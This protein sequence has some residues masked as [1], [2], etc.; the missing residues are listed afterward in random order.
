MSIPDFAAYL[1]AYMV[2]GVV[3]VL[4]SL[5]LTP[6]GKI[7]RGA[8][9]DV[10][11]PTGATAPRSRAEAVI[12]GI[13]ESVLGIAGIGVHD[14]FFALGAHSLTLV[15]IAA[16]LRQRLGAT[17]SVASLF[18]APT[19]A[20]VAR[21]VATG[22]PAGDPLAPVLTLHAGGVGA[23]LFCLPP[24]SG[25]TW[26]YAALRRY[27]D[28]PLV[29]LQSPTLSG[30]P[31]PASLAALAG[32]HA[33][34]IVALQPDGPVRLLGW[35]FG[36]ALALCIAAQLRDH[37]R[38]VAFL[39]MLDTRR[40]AP[41]PGDPAGTEIASLLAE[42]GFEVPPGTAT[43][44]DA[45]RLIRGSDDPIGVLTDEQIA[46][47]VENYLT[48]DRL[49]ATADY[50]DH[51][52]PVLFVD[53]TEPTPDASSGWPGLPGLTRHKLPVTHAEMLDASTLELLGP[54]LAE[55]LRAE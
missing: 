32:E 38:E 27:L 14:D 41:V 15:R 22:A 16:E 11:A 43:V 44:A 29:G 34:R 35:S 18:G 6:N 49:M 36:G 19:V 42:L 31:E 8:L 1:P 52:G 2:P 20:G 39:G 25:L 50:P 30:L 23:P 4:P 26:Q 53:A 51:D 5:P 48:S 17:V 54:I 40:P 33:D 45:V 55:S 24:A 37:G 46:L 13:V 9:P 12:S 47:V 7:D 28:V 10:D 3:H 21:L